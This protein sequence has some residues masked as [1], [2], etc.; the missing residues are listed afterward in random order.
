VTDAVLPGGVNQ[1]MSDTTL[2][3]ERHVLELIA[4]GGPLP[5]VLDA[6][7]ALIEDPP[8]LRASVYLL[9]RDARTM[10][11]VAGPA[12][13]EPWRAA[14]RSFP[15]TPAAGACGAALSAR[16]PVVVDNVQT[17]PLYSPDWRDAARASGIVAVWSS[18]FFATDGRRLGTFALVGTIPWSPGEEQRRRVSRAAYLAGIAVE[19]HQTEASIRESEQR[20]STAFYA[21]P[22]AMAIAG[23]EDKRFRYVNDKFLDLWGRS[24]AE[25]VGRTSMELGLWID[26]DDRA[27]IWRAIEEPGGV[28]EF[29]VKGRGRTG[30]IDLL[31]W[32]QRI[33][34]LGEPCVLWIAGDITE[35]KHAEAALAQSARLLRVVLDSLPV[36]VAVVNAAGDIVL[37]NPA[38]LQIWAM[39]ITDGRERWERSKGWWLATGRPVAPTEWASIRALKHGEASISEMLEIEAAD[40]VRRIIENSAVPIRDDAGVVTGAV[41]VNAD[42]S[43]RHKAERE[44]H[45]S[46]AQL[47]ALT[48]RLMRA[49]DDERRRIAQMLHETTAQD[50]AALKMQ[51]GSLT[52]SELVMSDQGRAAVRESIELAER[53][54]AS[55]R[56]LSYLLHPPFLDEAGV[57]SALRWYAEGFSKRSGIAVD[58][59][60]PPGFPRLPRDI[61]TALFRVVQEA[62]MNIH[63]HA[64]SPSAAI[65]LHLRGQ[66]LTLEVEDSGHGMPDSL[67]QLPAGGGALG[68]GVA[69]MR[70]RLQQL[71][72]VLDIESSP[73][74]TIVRARVPVAGSES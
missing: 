31:L 27:A 23:F 19:L 63:R 25:V 45:E 46:L 18:P 21:G 11:F 64:D 35:R 17:S 20:F 29:E 3:G 50:L 70:E 60:L 8:R 30:T 38:S 36:G 6:I 61:E 56:T 41:I 13:P 14:T 32:A 22:A 33:Q 62:L 65:R 28:H 53:S 24:R 72:G 16:E 26:P 12:V 10:S 7:C 66:E 40:G 4:T 37:T 44:L 74:G 47:R 73:R 34:I 58:L 49:Q 57:V 55:I 48:G 59:D 9:D 5:A 71:G 1:L 69:G 42:I 52:R 68:V 15:V 39:T 51:L 2:S 67:T 54:M 43:A